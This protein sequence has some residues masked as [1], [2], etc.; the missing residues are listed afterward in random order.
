MVCVQSIFVCKNKSSCVL[1]N[2]ISLFFRL[3]T[4]SGV[5]H[6]LKQKT[7]SCKEC[8][9]V[10]IDPPGSTL[11]NKVKYNI[12]YTP[13]QKERALLRHRYDT[14]AE[15]IG[16]DRIT[17]NFAIGVDHDVID[18]AILIQDQDAVDIAH[19]LLKEEGLFVGSSSAMNVAGLIRFS[20][21]SANQHD[22]Q[23]RTRCIV[24]V[25][26]DG[27]QRHLTRFWNRDFIRNRGLLWPSDDEHLWHSRLDI[28]FSSK[29]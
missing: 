8:T 5:G 19:W 10:L 15:G 13:Q 4:I 18:D 1:I 12:A 22:M 29:T 3:G 25:I 28:I 7:T 9:I 23:K 24:T 21:Q 17:H 11:Y 26:C 14:I 6:Y 2:I 16:L 20:L 27:G